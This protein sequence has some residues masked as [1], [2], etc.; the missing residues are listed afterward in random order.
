MREIYSSYYEKQLAQLGEHHIFV[1]VT[2]SSPVLI[3]L[4]FLEN[5]RRSK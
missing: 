1:G 2:G 3:L 5:E 4:F